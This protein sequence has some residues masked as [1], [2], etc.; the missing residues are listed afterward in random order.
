MVAI[1]KALLARPVQAEESFLPLSPAET[2][3]P[4]LGQVVE[5]DFA[6]D[7]A[8]LEASLAFLHTPT[9]CAWKSTAHGFL[10]NFL[11]QIGV[12]PL[13]AIVEPPAEAS[14]ANS[15]EAVLAQ[16][17][18]DLSLLDSTML[19]HLPSTIAISALFLSR[20]TLDH[21]YRLPLTLTYSH[22]LIHTSCREALALH[23]GS[24]PFVARDPTFASQPFGILPLG[25]YVRTCPQ[26]TQ[27]FA[28]CIVRLYFLLDSYREH[29]LLQHPEPLEFYNLAGKYGG[30]ETN[31]GKAWK[32]GLTLPRTTLAKAVIEH[33][34]GL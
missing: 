10:H 1:V 31:R 23:E 20:L 17:F 6:M 22:G 32:V 11:A 2:L 13:T 8:A 3:P 18:V 12:A 21:L 28:T 5:E 30:P 14:V 4:L 26:E 19:Q 34:K 29:T 27:S 16:I 33:V 15:E 25:S 24:R 9:R 7:Q